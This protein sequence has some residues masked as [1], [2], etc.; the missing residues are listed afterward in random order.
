VGLFL[1]L[2]LNV[3][4]AQTARSGGG[5]TSQSVASECAVIDALAP[6]ASP[7]QRGQI[8]GFTMTLR[9]NGTAIVTESA[10]R[11]GTV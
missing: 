3:A 6:L 8:F 11:P 7:Y 1:V 10:N 4:L 9:N 5:A 2:S